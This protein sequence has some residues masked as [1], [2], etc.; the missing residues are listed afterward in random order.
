MRIV[1]APNS[2]K[3]CMNARDAAEALA[4]G[5]RS[6]SPRAEIVIIP[7]S[8]G[9]DGLVSV[10]VGTLGGNIIRSETVDALGRTITAA[11]L[12]TDR[13]AVIESALASGLARLRGVSE[14]APLETSTLGTGL[15]MK[16]ALD[17]GCRH[18]VVGLGG[19]ATVDAGCGAASALGFLF[20]D[21][22]GR[23]IPPGGAG[24]LKL[25]HIRPPR[26]WRAS[27]GKYRVTA[28]VDVM[29][30]LLGSSGAARVFAP[31]KGATPDDVALL[32]RGLALWAEIV[33]RNMGVSVADIPGAGAAG[34][35][36]AGFAAYFGA[37]IENGASWVA[38]QS[39]LSAAIRKADVV[40]T[41][42]GRV[43]FQT[44]F[45]KGP[46][47]VCRLAK[48]MNKPVM[49]FGGLV[50]KGLDPAEIGADACIQV[51]P[52]EISVDEA[53]RTASA[54]LERSAARVVAQMEKGS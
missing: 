49:V 18:I 17:A 12:K 47:C 50:E 31:Q 39:G 24:L 52:G 2:F 48:S 32:E 23:P 13:Y 35:M 34:G 26:G 11:W 42:E 14:Y 37:E 22:R 9:G 41:G 20:E 51:S 45:G 8:D 4:R 33:E 19:S 29:N 5:A 21:S 3:G 25:A 54:N 53:V 16:A 1:I 6:A 28:L 36:G 30:P 43:D 38:G 10:L 15:L 27:A 46:A 7:L 44:R 40:F